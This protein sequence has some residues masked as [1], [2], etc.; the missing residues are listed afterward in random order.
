MV[1]DNFDVHR[2][3]RRPDKANSKL[4]VD[5]NAVLAL[6]I[7]RQRFQSIARG[8]PQEIERCCGVQLIEFAAG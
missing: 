6:T 4:I 1:I 2:A 7:A 3:L 5:A 8:N